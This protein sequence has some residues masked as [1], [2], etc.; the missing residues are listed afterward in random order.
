MICIF[1]TQLAK[2]LYCFFPA[3]QNVHKVIRMDVHAVTVHYSYIMDQMIPD[4]VVPYLVERR[5][6]SPKNAAEVT[7]IHSKTKKVSAILKAL[8]E[9]NVVG[10]LSTFCAALISAGQ[11]HI[12]DRLTDSECLLGGIMYI[13]DAVVS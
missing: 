1:V 3:M 10:R 13:L 6:L 11:P 2:L 4:A 5:L 9:K 8:D 12:A 7:A